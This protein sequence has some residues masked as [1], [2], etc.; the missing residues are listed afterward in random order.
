[1]DLR[2]LQRDPARFQQEIVLP[3]G[4]GPRRFGDIM[5]PFQREAFDAINPSL[6]AI[7]RAEEPPVPRFWIERTKG[8]SKDSDVAVCMLWLVGFCRRPL[9][10]QV[11]AADLQQAQEVRHIVD[12]ILR[13]N[14]PVNKALREWLDVQANKIVN[15]VTTS[16][17]EILSCDS[18]GSHGSRPDVVV[19]DELSHVADEAFMQTMMDNLAKM[20]RSLGIIATNSG[21][22]DTWQHRWR[23]SFRESDRW[24]FLEH[25]QP[26]PWIAAAD[27]EEARRRSPGTRFNRLWLGQWVSDAGD[28]LS[29]DDIESAFTR[30][31]P[32][33]GTEPGFVHAAGLDLGLAKH[34]SALVVVGQSIGWTEEIPKPQHVMSSTQKALASVGM[35]TP[36]EEPPEVRVHEGTNKIRLA[37]LR[38]WRPDSGRVSLEYVKQHIVDLHRRFNLQSLSMDPWQGEFLA[39]Q[40]RSE[41]VPV[42]LVPQNVAS[43]Q[44]QAIALIEA[45]QQRQLELYDDEDLRADLRRLRIKDTGTRVRLVSPEVDSE[46]GTTHGDLA[47]A[48]S[49]ALAAVKRNSHFAAAAPAGTLCMWP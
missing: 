46:S 20:P 36:P 2:Q 19:A 27:V 15:T 18:R 48:L 6:I 43:L 49:F 22:L 44:D 10:I 40:L 38:V 14:A 23:E 11:G 1:M 47:S 17:I 41:G 3:T 25:K 31:G 12:S 5:A 21:H 16:T 37:H 39:E 32:M 33:R 8:G 4:S 28:A 45:F 9:R 29:S 35:F 26:A 42:Q 30:P 13:A 7:A 34:A 24:L